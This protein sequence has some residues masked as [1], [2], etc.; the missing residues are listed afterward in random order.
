[1][2]IIDDFLQKV[3]EIPLGKLTEEQVEA[4]VNELKSG[5]TASDNL[6]IKELLVK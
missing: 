2:K 5:V 6:Y 1:M 3:T 4:R